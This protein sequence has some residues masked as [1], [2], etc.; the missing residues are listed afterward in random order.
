MPDD[1][2]GAWR[3]ILLIANAVMA[4]CGMVACIL[5]AILRRRPIRREWQDPR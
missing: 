2:L 4:L 5:A 1:E 3:I